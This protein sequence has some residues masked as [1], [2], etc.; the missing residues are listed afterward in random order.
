MF[1]SVLARRF[2]CVPWLSSEISQHGLARPGEWRPRC[3]PAAAEAPALRAQRP[4]HWGFRF[5]ANARGP[6]TV[7]SERRIRSASE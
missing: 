7:S 6:S 4:F 3:A 5:S 2:L 1:S